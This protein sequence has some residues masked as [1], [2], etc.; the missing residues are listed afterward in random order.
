M[1][2]DLIVL[3]EVTSDFVSPASV[4]A[5]LSADP[6]FAHD[7][8]ALYRQ[9]WQPQAWA[10]EDPP[11]LQCPVLYGPGGFALR[12]EPGI[13]ELYHMM[14]FSRFAADVALRESMRRACRVL[15]DLVGSDRVIFTHELIPTEGNTLSAIARSLSA[16]I[17]PPAVT[18][19]ELSEAEYFGPRA[20]LIDN[21]SDI[22]I[23]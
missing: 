1:S 4:Q 10:M 13:L 11:R 8:I 20:W 19:K 15:A 23:P 6:H 18:Y 17:G 22:G 14:P 16:R 21:F 2:T 5:T 12:F 7:I 3:F 9:H